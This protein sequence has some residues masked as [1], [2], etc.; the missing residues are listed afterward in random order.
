MNDSSASGCQHGILCL[1]FDDARYTQWLPL[2]PEFSRFNARCTFFFDK[3]IDTQAINAMRE[4]IAAGH[5]VGLHTI[6]HR[7]ADTGFAELGAEGYM[8]A[9]L[10]PQMEAC[11]RAGI[12]APFLGYPNGRSTPEIDRYMLESAGFERLRV[13]TG[14]TLAKCRAF[15]DYDDFYVDVDRAAGLRTIP[16]GVFGADFYGT[17]QANLDAAI[18]RAA[19]RNQLICLTSHG[20][21]DHPGPVDV[22]IDMLREVMRS[23]TRMGV[24]MCSFADLAELS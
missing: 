16:S 2:L 18:A 7:N 22:H 3:E 8:A 13:H 24:R 11:R 4:L 6:H 1:T 20:I 19:R 9:E 10:A 21:S 23:A 17:T 14:I 15:A 12:S 5:A